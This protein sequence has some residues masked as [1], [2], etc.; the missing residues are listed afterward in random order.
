MSFKQK[1]KTEFKLNERKK[2]FINLYKFIKNY[3]IPHV[4]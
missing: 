4:Y 2:M 3:N 1:K